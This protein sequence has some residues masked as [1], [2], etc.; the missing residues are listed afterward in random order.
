MG[1]LPM[2][3]CAGLVS[4]RLARPGDAKHYAGAAYF[5]RNEV[6]TFSGLFE[7]FYY[8]R[9]YR[10]DGGVVVWRALLVA[11]RF[12]APSFGWVRGSSPCWL[13]LGGLAMLDPVVAE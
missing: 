2:G 4:E 1:R 7:M 6:N 10:K 5:N 13:A 11:W 3:R 12:S 9:V 8:H